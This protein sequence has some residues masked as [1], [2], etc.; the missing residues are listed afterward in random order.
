MS[1]SKLDPR[2]KLSYRLGEFARLTSLST[3]YL[4]D[5]IKAGKLPA[6]KFSR[7]VL[8]LASDG[9]SWLESLPVYQAGDHDLL[10]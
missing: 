3:D 5:Q 8:I 1:G 2:L 6:R 4:R 10:D 7:F 9:K